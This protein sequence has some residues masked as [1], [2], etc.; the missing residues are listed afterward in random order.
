MAVVEGQSHVL[1]GEPLMWYGL[2]CTCVQKSG[3]F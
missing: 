2:A 1:G 3:L